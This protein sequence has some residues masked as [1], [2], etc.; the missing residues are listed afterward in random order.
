MVTVTVSSKGQIVIP[1]K[2]RETLGLTIGKK[3]KLFQE[4]KKIILVTE[5]E[6]KPSELFVSASPHAVDK[7]LKASRKI[8]ETKIKR[9]L[10]DLGIK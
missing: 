9:L 6:V 7:A 3:L 1:K 10:N 2:L 4:N 8:D 5:T